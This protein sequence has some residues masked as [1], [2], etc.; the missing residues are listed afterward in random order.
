MREMKF[1][2]LVFLLTFT[3]VRSKKHIKTLVDS[4]DAVDH[5]QDALFEGNLEK[6][7]KPIIVNQREAFLRT[8][9]LRYTFAAKQYEQKDK[10]VLNKKTYS[11]LGYAKKKFID[12]T[13]QVTLHTEK[14]NVKNFVDVLLGSDF[15]LKPFLKEY[16]DRLVNH[17]PRSLLSNKR[18]VIA[19]PKQ[20]ELQLDDEHSTFQNELLGSENQSKNENITKE[21][22]ITKALYDAIAKIAEVGRGGKTV[23]LKVIQKE[24]EKNTGLSKKTPK[25]TLQ[26]HSKKKYITLTN[27]NTAGSIKKDI[28]IN[29]SI[30]TDHL[31]H[32]I[33]YYTKGN[34]IKKAELI[35][36]LL[37]KKNSNIP[38]NFN[39]TKIPVKVITQTKKISEEP[40]NDVKTKSKEV[41]LNASFSD[42]AERH[43]TSNGNIKFKVNKIS[44]NKHFMKKKK[45]EIKMKK[46][47]NLKD[48]DL[49]ISDGQHLKSSDNQFLNTVVDQSQNEF[50]KFEDIKNQTMSFQANSNQTTLHRATL[51]QAIPPKTASDQTIPLHASSKQALTHLALLNKTS[52]THF[53]KNQEEFLEEHSRI[54]VKVKNL[55]NDNLKKTIYQNAEPQALMKQVIG[56]KKESLIEKVSEKKNAQINVFHDLDSKD[57]SSVTNKPI[58]FQPVLTVDLKEPAI[59]QSNLYDGYESEVTEFISGDGST[60]VPIA[61]AKPSSLLKNDEQQNQLDTEKDEELAKV[62][63]SQTLALEKLGESRLLN[64]DIMKPLQNISFKHLR[65]E[66][67]EKSQ[68][69]NSIHSNRVQIIKPKIISDV[70]ARHC[71]DD[72]NHVDGNLTSGVKEINEL[73]KSS[74]AIGCENKKEYNSTELNSS[75]TFSSGIDLEYL[76]NLFEDKDIESFQENY[77][78]AMKK[79]AFE[80]I[81]N[82]LNNSLSAFLKNFEN[83]G[84]E[85][86]MLMRKIVEDKLKQEESSI[87][88]QIDFPSFYHAVGTITLPYDDLVEPFEAWYAGE[89]NMSRIDYYYGMDKSYQRGDIGPHGVVVKLVPAHWGKH[90]DLNKNKISCWYK[91]E[92][93]WTKR[94]AQ[95][96]V[97]LN[98]KKFKYVGE[99]QFNGVPAFKFFYQKKFISK[100]NTYV[101]H[102]SKAKPHVPLRY[103]MIGYDHLLRSHYDHYIIDYLSFKPWK[104]DYTVLQIPKEYKCYKKLR[105]MKSHFEANPMWD[106]LHGEEPK[107]RERELTQTFKDFKDKHSKE[108]KDHTENHKRKNIFRHNSRFIHSHNRAN[109]SY[110]LEVNHLADLSEEEF[111]MLKGQPTL[112]TPQFKKEVN[113]IPALRLE[114]PKAPLPQNLDWRIYGAVSEVHSQSFCASCWAFSAV[115]AI[116]GAYTI[117]NGTLKEM[118]VQQLVD[119]SWGYNNNGCRGGWSWRALNFVGEHGLA[120]REAYGNY[121]AQEGYCH[122]GKNDNC[123][124]VK[125]M[126]YRTIEK[127]NAEKLKAALTL[128]GPGSVAVQCA[129][130]TFKFYSS[131]VYD[132]PKCTEVTDHA[133][134]IIGYGVENNKPYWLIKNSWGKLWGD[135]G[136]MKIDMN[137]NLCGVLTNGA[138]MVSFNNWKESKTFPFEKMKKSQPTV[139]VTNQ[140][141]ITENIELFEVPKHVNVYLRN[142]DK[143]KKH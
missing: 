12:K 39:F 23:K 122:C 78:R 65:P 89:L 44:H 142:L 61:L 92:S 24:K 49:S 13:N 110:S 98:V 14:D 19:D 69:I 50:K 99:E 10:N 129:R 62:F 82:K 138:L 1:H 66:K 113:E 130:K 125:K 135:N 88:Y 26:K 121:I 57:I 112:N 134:V 128:Y 75:D 136:Y 8:L 58:V 2:T 143:I 47:I 91:Q 105:Q 55:K 111:E 95:T 67:L 120:T 117:Y 52:Q 41:P 6:V 100:N 76:Q 21:Y 38:S 54:K 85:T 48:K 53:R 81:R 115:G 80:G 103:E 71:V 27:Q 139:S 42:V 93:I 68:K 4:N 33:H 73:T 7:E 84:T 79:E 96:V 64:P 109:R 132:D 35:K 16:A 124:G 118:A 141:E 45:V 74:F 104:F 102:V 34:K 114:I 31:S 20:N 18:I 86:E 106:F 22:V 5:F 123:D 11:Q 72:D 3:I 59:N 36:K 28:S 131:G 119:C 43:Q 97:P 15:A 107:H 127:K 137:N 90:T 40:T 140:K 83:A 32:M 133:V 17:S 70:E 63:K 101:L 116:E 126:S 51:F 87:R 94:R 37:K 56:E 29:K 108:Y 77:T 25:K 60:F 30:P 46:K 9:P